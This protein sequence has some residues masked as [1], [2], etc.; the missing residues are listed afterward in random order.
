M[1]C[2]NPRRRADLYQKDALRQLFDRALF[3]KKLTISLPS[4]K[5]SINQNMINDFRA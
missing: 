4:T 5:T 2:N 3:M 1:L